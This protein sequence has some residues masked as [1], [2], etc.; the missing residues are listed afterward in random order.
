MSEE[1]KY[2][3]HYSEEGFW[4]KLKKFAI[5]AGIKVVYSGLIL[6]FALENPKV[7]L[8]DKAIIYAA[9]GYLILP[10]DAI[11]DLIPLIGFTDD[12]GVLLFAAA[13]IAL[14]IDNE[15]KLKAK[16]KLTE[17]FGDGAID[18][19][20]IIEVEKQIDGDD[21]VSPSLAK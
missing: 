12:L 1:T 11:P 15:V 20:E 7:S 8:R 9:L 18:Q 4:Q 21:D 16:A 17:Y 3:K 6:Y 19:D 10:V 13:R 5:A 2:A 14:T